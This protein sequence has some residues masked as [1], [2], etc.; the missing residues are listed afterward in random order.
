MTECSLTI[1]ASVND[2]S[3]E[4]AIE[5]NSQPPAILSKNALKRQLKQEKYHEAKEEIKQKRK[6]ARKAKKDKSKLLPALNKSKKVL[7]KYQTPVDTN[8]VIDLDYQSLM[9]EKNL[10]S[11]AAQLKMSYS[12]LNIV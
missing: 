7:P 10:K 6:V 1:P 9:Q 2:D 3:T 12:A 8:I 11:L 5:N 4:L